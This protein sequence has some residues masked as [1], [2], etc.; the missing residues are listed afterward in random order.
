MAYN[1]VNRRS[2]RGIWKNIFEKL[3]SKSHDSLNLIDS[4]IVK[5]QWP[6]RA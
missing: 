6:E 3:A 2:R 4:T 1:R 5:D